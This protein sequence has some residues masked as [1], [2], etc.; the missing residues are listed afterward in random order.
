[1]SVASCFKW[2]GASHTGMPLRAQV[3]HTLMWLFLLGIICAMS[4]W[5][6]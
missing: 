6:A 5:L 2:G 1:M 3:A 4:M